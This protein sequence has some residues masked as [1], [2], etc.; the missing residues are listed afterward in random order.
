MSIITKTL[1]E[2]ARGNGRMDRARIKAL[3]D[4]DIERMAEDEARAEG[5]PLPD[6]GELA[7]AKVVVPNSSSDTP[8]M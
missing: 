3:S 4:E 1:D 2:I 5:L 7:Q 6:D 8:S